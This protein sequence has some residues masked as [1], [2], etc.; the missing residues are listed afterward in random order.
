MT[1]VLAHWPLDWWEASKAGS[2]TRGVSS[3]PSPAKT[4]HRYRSL[5]HDNSLRPNRISSTLCYICL[6]YTTW[7]SGSDRQPNLFLT[8]KVSFSLFIVFW[9]S[10]SFPFCQGKNRPSRHSQRVNS[11]W[12]KPSLLLGLHRIC[13]I[14]EKTSPRRFGYGTFQR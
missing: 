7:P 1:R 4:R 6:Q 8:R 2:L 14:A 3:A 5:Y 10:T 12:P 11:P 13:Q 9:H